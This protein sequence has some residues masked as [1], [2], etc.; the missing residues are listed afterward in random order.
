MQ[1]QNI[2]A[3]LIMERGGIPLFFMKIDPRA[4]DLDPMLVSGF[5]TAIQTFSKEVV[6]RRSSRF[7]VDYGAR[8]FT[9][10]SGESTDLVAVSMGECEED[11][12]L[13]L[14]SLLEE[15][16]GVWIKD[17]TREKMDTLDINTE[18]S[19]FR[20]GVLQNLSFKQVMGSWIP[21]FVGSPTSKTTES[22]VV[23]FIDGSRNVDE[24][25]KESGL[26]RED[27]TFE[28]TRLW[29]LGVLQFRSILAPSDVVVSTSRLDRFLQSSSSQ[30]EELARTNPELLALLPRMSTLFDGRRTVGA[31]TRFLSEQYSE[32]ALM[33]AF[34]LLMESKAIDV[35]TPEKRR[36]LLTKEATEIA[37][38]VAENV[39]SEEKAYEYLETA[40]AKVAVPEVVGE[41]H[42]TDGK[43]EL[44]YGSRLLEGL[45][46]RRLMELY[47]DWIK[48]LAQFL[49]AI[50]KSK[51]RTYAEGLT[52]AYSSY[53][54]KRYTADDLRGFEEISYWLELNCVGK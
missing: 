10:L 8:L 29:A 15:F 32:R 51:I 53:L 23:P 19:D 11:V 16:E 38:K 34:D 1:G 35:L 4:Q 12:I 50:D 2:Q 48:L 40:L 17:L 5:F 20:E 26:N 46:P 39:Y 45:D 24:I 52:D 22:I 42:L 49:G 37:I 18:F 14:T 31:I 27:V 25:V 47:A 30:R 36:I 6:D 44:T 33:Q 43:W 13:T 7:Q 21:F 3:I 41:V 28:I 54:L 9:V